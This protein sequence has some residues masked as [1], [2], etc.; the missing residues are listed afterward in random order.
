MINKFLVNYLTHQND[1]SVRKHMLEAMSQI[2]W[3]T[4]EDKEA[5][6]LVKKQKLDPNEG[7]RNAGFGDRLINY[8]LDD[9]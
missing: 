3:F 8:F 4:M 9:E 5:L 1:P 2:L 7:K 6:G